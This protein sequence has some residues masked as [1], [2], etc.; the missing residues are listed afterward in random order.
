MSSRERLIF[1]KYEATFPLSK[2]NCL[3][4][5]GY[6]KEQLCPDKSALWMKK[7]LFCSSYQ[8]LW[9]KHSHDGCFQAANTVMSLNTA[10]R[11]D[12]PEWV[13]SATPLPAWLCCGEGKMGSFPR[14]SSREGRW[15]LCPTYLTFIEV[16]VS[17]ESDSMN[18][19]CGQKGFAGMRLWKSN[20]NTGYFFSWCLHT[21]HFSQ[22]A[23]LHHNSIGESEAWIAQWHAPGHTN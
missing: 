15:H 22:S 20:S 10:L 21:Q 16:K 13:C 1:L 14:C 6:K 19:E 7:A 5:K 4:Q 8:F 12:V 23:R 17:T 2:L 18:P 3:G 9:H 11:R